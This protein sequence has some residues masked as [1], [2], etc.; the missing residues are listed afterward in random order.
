M[1]QVDGDGF[2]KMTIDECI[3][4]WAE[5]ITD[6]N[7]EEKVFVKEHFNVDDIFS[8]SNEEWRELMEELNDVYYFESSKLEHLPPKKEDECSI[9]WYEDNCSYAGKMASGIVTSMCHLRH[10]MQQKVK[11]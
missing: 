8:L 4:K 9:K 2:S 3:S 5:S 1:T 11:R 6:L 7:D 10:R